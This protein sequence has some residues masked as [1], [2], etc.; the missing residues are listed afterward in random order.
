MTIEKILKSK[1][2]FTLLSKIIKFSSL[3]YSFSVEIICDHTLKNI[4]NV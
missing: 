3:Y 2:S 4:Y 1:N